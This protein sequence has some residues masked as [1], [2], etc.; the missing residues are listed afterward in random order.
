MWGGGAEWLEAALG[1]QAVLWASGQA[2]RGAGDGRGQGQGH[3]ERTGSATR[4]TW[5]LMPS[6]TFQRTQGESLSLNFGLLPHP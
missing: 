3:R 4:Q 6:A 5:V 1:K 2:W